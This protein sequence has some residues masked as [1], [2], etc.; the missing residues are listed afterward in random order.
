MARRT[1]HGLTGTLRDWFS[2]SSLRTILYA[3]GIAILIRS[4]AYEPFNIPSGS[5]IPNLLIGDYLF[6]SKFSYGYSRYSLPF[7]IGLF[8]GRV[9]EEQPKRGDVAVF[10]LPRD[11]RTDYIKR[12]I[13]LPGD[14]I[15]MRGS[16]LYLNGKEVERRRVA[17]FERGEDKPSLRQF[18]ETLPN[19]VSYRILDTT[20]EGTLDDTPVYTVPPGHYFAMGDNR[21]NSLDSRVLSGVGYIPAANLIGRAEFLFFSTN[22]KAKLWEIWNWPRSIRFDRLFMPVE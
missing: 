2:G 21:D 19:G 4:F 9:F 15:Q 17:D 22:G 5:M 16:R 12:I 6:V 20:D 3:V 11:N 10:K 7:G 14:K 18:V 1:S 13:G 8:S